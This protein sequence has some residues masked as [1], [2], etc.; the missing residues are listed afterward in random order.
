MGGMTRAKAMQGDI[1]KRVD[2]FWPWS[3]TLSECGTT[4]VTSEYRQR[5]V[6]LPNAN[7]VSPSY[8]HRLIQS[9]NDGKLVELPSA[10]SL[11][12]SNLLSNH[13]TPQRNPPSH[14]TTPSNSILSAHG[15]SRQDQDV[16]N[17]NSE[18][19]PS[20]GDMEKMSSIESITL[21]YSY[22][23]SSQLE[24][25]RQ[26]YETTAQSQTERLEALEAIETKVQA[27]EHDKVEAIKA[28]EKAERRAEKA[29]E[30]TRTLQQSLSAE[31]A[32]AEG[33]SAR[34]NKLREDFA[35]VDNERKDKAEQIQNLEE[36]VRD[37]MFTLE[38][39]MKIQSAGGGEDGGEGGQLVIV[40]GKEK[41]KGRR[42]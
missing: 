27:A 30:V 41:R 39:G 34:V 3:W 23:L 10:S 20:S 1:G 2:M 37:L 13:S 38:A 21:E 29:T 18:A 6:D 24:A 40:P 28:R 16:I 42:S 36:T 32:M 17:G 19:G 4:R 25:M 5:S 7:L 31:R 12:T 11:V 26:H 35:K 14:Q 8:V 15:Q 22:L 33:L 9:R